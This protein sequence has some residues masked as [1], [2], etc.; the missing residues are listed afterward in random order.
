MHNSNNN[1]NYYLAQFPPS[2]FADNLICIDYNTKKKKGGLIDFCVFT[3]CCLRK[4][5]KRKNTIVDK[6]S[7]R[8]VHNSNNNNNNYHAQFPLIPPATSFVLLSRR[9]FIPTCIIIFVFTDGRPIIRS[10]CVVQ[11]YHQPAIH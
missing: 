7:I 9:V 8:Y 10:T 11:S 6:T 2:Y 5:L 3:A 4:T 1:N